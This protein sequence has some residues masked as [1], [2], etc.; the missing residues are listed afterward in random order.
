MVDA[1]HYEELHELV[2][3]SRA[4][5]PHRLTLGHSGWQ[6][7]VAT[8]ALADVVTRFLAPIYTVVPEANQEVEAWMITDPGLVRTAQALYRATSA[9]RHEANSLWLA[10]QY[11]L[12]AEASRILTLHHEDE[13]FVYIDGNADARNFD[14]ARAVRALLASKAFVAGA[15]AVHAAAIVASGGAY[16][17]CGPKRS[18]KTTNLMSA[19]RYLPSV[20][21]LANDRVYLVATPD[22]VRAFG[23]P[24]SI[25]IRPASYQAVPEL[26]SRFGLGREMG[27][28]A[29]G[30]LNPASSITE[31]PEIYLSS[32]ELISVFGVK[33]VTNAPFAGV[34]EVTSEPL[35]DV[36]A[37][38]AGDASQASKVICANLHDRIETNFAYW[39]DVYANNPAYDLPSLAGCSYWAL[40]SWSDLEGAWRTSPFIT[41]EG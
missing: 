2:A 24:H 32:E 14:A 26:A 30:Y 19:L 8:D 31:Q 9:T 20:S 34:I 37:W 36:P 6:A 29:R 4:N 10:G 17:L 38:S 40:N 21:Y 27:G 25:P 5:P 13:R 1:A 35:G 16:L 18:G 7:T 3:A 39:D 11:T 33:E 22:G 15:V 23:S 28:T 41:N 12:R